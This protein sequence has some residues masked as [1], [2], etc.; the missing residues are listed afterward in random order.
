MDYLILFIISVLSI[1]IFLV[2]VFVIMATYYGYRQIKLLPRNSKCTWNKDVDEL[3]G[4]YKTQCGEVFNDATESGN[5]V[6]DWITYCPYCSGKVK[7]K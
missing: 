2:F 6:T 3:S 5:P 4:K 7:L 1:C